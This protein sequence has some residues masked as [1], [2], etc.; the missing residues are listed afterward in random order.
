MSV[1]TKL[2]LLTSL[3][4]YNWN[5]K[6]CS[7]ALY[8]NYHIQWKIYRHALPHLDL[9]VF[10]QFYLTSHQ[11][12][13]EVLL[14]EETK[15]LDRKTKKLVLFCFQKVHVI[16]T[17]FGKYLIDFIDEIRTSFYSE[18]FRIVCWDSSYVVLILWIFIYTT[19]QLC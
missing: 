2:L 18:S 17:W 10:L 13:Y 3:I 9:M 11:L 16:E 14:S 1:L 15:K 12:V 5:C 7:H 6:T 19:N 8:I 4:I